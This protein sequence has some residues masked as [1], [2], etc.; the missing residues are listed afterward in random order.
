M[1]SEQEYVDR[2]VMMHSHINIIA[3]AKTARI[4][5]VGYKKK[6]QIKMKKQRHSN[7]IRDSAIYRRPNL[8]ASSLSA[9]K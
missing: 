3:A 4:Q 5:Y 8:I 1:Q 7:D 2:Y 9:I 6:Q